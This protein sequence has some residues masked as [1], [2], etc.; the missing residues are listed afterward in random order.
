MKKIGILSFF[1]AFYP[2]R[3]GGELRLHHLARQLA[4]RGFHIEMA[5]PTMGDAPQE[6]IEHSD[7]FIERRFPKP[8]IYNKG[9]RFMD[10]AAGFRECSGL[11]CSL[12]APYHTA[13]RREAERLAAEVD[14]LVHESPFLLPLMPKR[15]KKG[16][17]L[18]Y[19]SYNVETY[20]AR[21]MFGSS[22]QGR[23]ATAWIAHLEKRLL[24][25][26]DMILACSEKDID[27]FAA[28]FGVE[29]A[30]MMLVPNGVDIHEIQPCPHARRRAEAR[31]LL[32]LSSARNACFFMGSY[33]PPNME[34]V[35][36][37]IQLLAPN[38]PEVDFLV[39][40][41]VC[42]AF[43]GKQIPE[44]VRLLGL[45]DENQKGA[46]LHGCD[47]ALNPMLT[48]SGTNLKILE[49]FAAGLP[50]LATPHGARG[51]DLESRRHALIYET[52]SLVEGLEELLGDAH[53]QDMLAREGRKLVENEFSWEAIG[54]QL[55]DLYSLKLGRRIVIL[56]DFDVHPA[57]RGGQVRIA[58]VAERLASSG[59]NVTVLTLT[60]EQE[61]RRLQL[62]PRLEELNVPRSTLHRQLDSLVSHLVGCGADDVTAQLF[63]KR[64]SKKFTRLL[65]REM[66]WAEGILQ[67]HPYL[68]E[69]TRK[70]AGK[71]HV[72]FDSLNTEYLLKKALYRH[73]FLS[74]VLIERVRQ[75]EISACRRS[76]AIFCVSEENRQQLMDLVPDIA[77]RSYV[78]PNGV[79]CSRVQ[80]LEPEER[81]R[82]RRDVGFGREFVAV[83]LGSGHPP[84]A[85]AA[86]F[87]IDR[88][89][90]EHPRVLFLIVGSV[91]GW[92][93]NRPVP[94]NVLLMGMVSAEVK[95]FV[96]QTAD[97]A[98]NPMMT[99]SG[100]SLKLFDYLAAGLPVVSTAIGARG[101]DEEA[102]K[103][104]VLVEADDFSRT[105]RELLNDPGRC[106][107]LAHNARKFAEEYF[108]WSVTLSHMDEIICSNRPKDAQPQVAR[109][110]LKQSST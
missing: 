44:N 84:N 93:W 40:G 89:S 5:S 47:V 8:N 62:G 75:A 110:S 97:F 45:V 74:R 72:Y 30:R 6:T 88:I 51:I 42:Q 78:C 92:F 67:V 101:V 81:R 33:H 18:I 36:L 9:H 82:L 11:V 7:H 24:R 28:D 85:E 63:T 76:D 49:Y 43:E 80:V 105:L 13:L 68:E 91:S 95:D 99:G 34:A 56:N 26:S 32:G 96:L 15:R 54:D 46:L 94:G 2:P 87:I 12:T 73:S 20:M 86:R 35:D 83:F 61:G 107:D 102:M 98:L 1:P 77:T 104:I 106:A 109:E 71:K 48:G 103:G 60:R 59:I 17:L 10:L 55:A 23:L 69:L 58:A 38:F 37:V 52:P 3:S 31:E 66:Q 50:V 39:A 108:D 79:D 14:V 22:W 27:Q 4:R 19:N 41:R 100:T 64:L 65:D 16:Q 53:L 90:R 25:E 29:R 70:Y 21:D 57:E